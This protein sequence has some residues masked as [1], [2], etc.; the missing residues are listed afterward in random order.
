MLQL[1]LMEFDYASPMDFPFKVRADLFR[2]DKE[3]AEL[4]HYNTD[5]D[6]AAGATFSGR[7]LHA[8]SRVFLGELEGLKI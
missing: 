1:I 7:C 6:Q 5:S 4:Y 3:M 8:G 2:L